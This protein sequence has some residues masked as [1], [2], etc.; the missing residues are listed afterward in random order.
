[1]TEI[2]IKDLGLKGVVTGLSQE[3]E[4]EHRG[5]GEEKGW[6]TGNR[7]AGPRPCRHSCA[8]DGRE[9]TGEA[10]KVPSL[11]EPGMAV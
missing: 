2:V 5:G 7:M 1:M 11:Q 3:R 6:E 10:G 4:A 8:L 9:F